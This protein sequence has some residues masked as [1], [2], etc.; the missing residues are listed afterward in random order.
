ML[1]LRCIGLIPDWGTKI[2]H[3]A[4]CSQ[5]KK[6]KKKTK[7]KT[8]NIIC[9]SQIVKF[10]IFSQAH[11]YIFFEKMPIEVFYLFHWV[12]WFFD[13]KLFELFVYFGY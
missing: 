1:P 12:V 13:M 8:K 4:Q 6:E 5:K 11:L 7:N 2:Q 9:I 10:C 3:T